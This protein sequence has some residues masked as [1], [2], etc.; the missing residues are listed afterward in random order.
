MGHSMRNKERLLHPIEQEQLLL[1]FLK[2]GIKSKFVFD[3][4]IDKYDW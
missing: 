1:F 4:Y 3:E 2:H